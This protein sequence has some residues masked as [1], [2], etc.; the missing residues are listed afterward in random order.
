MDNKADQSDLLIL[1]AGP[2]AL[3]AAIAACQT[4]QR[5]CVIGQPHTGQFGIGES[6]PAVTLRIFKRLGL[7]HI[8]QF[9]GP[10][11]LLPCSAN[12]SQWG[13]DKWEVRD[14]IHDPEGGGWHIDRMELERRLFQTAIKIGVDIRVAKLTTLQDDGR[15]YR[16]HA[17]TGTA[18]IQLEAPFLIDATGR[19]AWLVRR[20]A[21]APR[22]Y[23]HQFSIMG[24]TKTSSND[25][26]NYTRIKAVESGW[27]YTSRLPGQVRA[28]GFQGLPDQ[29]QTY[30]KSPDIFMNDICAAEF[31]PNSEIVFDW[32][33]SLQSSDSSVTLA[34]KIAGPRWLAI[35]D[36]ALSFDPLSAQGLY[37]AFYSAI[38]AI[39]SVSQILKTPDDTKPILA[40]YCENVASVF[41]AN[42]RARALFYATENRFPEAPYWDT[43]KHFTN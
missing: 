10:N 32:L 27:W 39:E 43:Q 9:L 3:C 1:G 36:A 26:E 33:A 18:S 7:G 23:S 12:M 13:T 31:F 2:A 40:K 20:L 5:V 42:Q 4:G 28:F 37:F 16:I 6:L 22:K 17:Q 11:H 14:S 41:Q 38:R 34:P 24:W 30:Y 21:G 35:G 15:L 25:V 29:V 19:K 8:E